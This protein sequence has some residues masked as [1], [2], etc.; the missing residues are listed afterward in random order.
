MINAPDLPGATCNFQPYSFYLGGKRTYWG[1]PNNPDYDLG[2]LLGSPCDTLVGINEPA[3]FSISGEL[4]VYYEGNW[5][6]AFIN[7]HHVT[8]NRYSLEVYD[9]MGKSVFRESGVLNPPYFTKNLNCS[10]F[11]TGVYTVVLQTERE[12]LV[13][14]FVR[15]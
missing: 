11:A 1:L 12:R 4:F 7:A 3:L 14:R 2:P 15:K 5:Q 6:T 13:K 10:S 8:G 9:I